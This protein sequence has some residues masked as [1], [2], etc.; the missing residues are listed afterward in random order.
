MD[1]WVG[2]GGMGGKLE[3]MIGGE[4]EGMEM[5]KLGELK[6]GECGSR[7]GSVNVKCGVGKNGDL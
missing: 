1:I 6:D 3:S 2:G 7:E 5:V 4:E